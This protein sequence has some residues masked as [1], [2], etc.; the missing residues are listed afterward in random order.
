[1]EDKFGIVWDAKEGRLRCNAHIFNLAAKDFLFCIDEDCIHDDSLALAPG[2]TPIELERRQWRS[3]GALGKLYNFNISVNNSAEYKEKWLRI[4]GSM[5]TR[6]NDTRW[7]SW[8]AQIAGF[9]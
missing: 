6:D 3:R 8:E 9:L 5:V 2:L 7:G 4:A 1:M